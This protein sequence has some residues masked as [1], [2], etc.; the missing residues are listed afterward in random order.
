MSSAEP[1]P[2]EKRRSVA[3]MINPFDLFKKLKSHA[4]ACDLNED[5]FLT[6]VKNLDLDETSLA[7]H[8]SSARTGVRSPGGTR[9]DILVYKKYRLYGRLLQLMGKPLAETYFEENGTATALNLE[10]LNRIINRGLA[11][12]GMQLRSTT[13]N[14]LAALA[15]LSSALRN[16]RRDSVAVTGDDADTQSTVS[17]LS[18]TV[19][20]TPSSGSRSI[21][22]AAA[23]GKLVPESI[24]QAFGA[25]TLTSSRSAPSLPEP[26]RLPPLKPARSS[27]HLVRASPRTAASDGDSTTAKIQALEQENATLRAT[28]EANVDARRLY[29]L[30]C[31][32]AQLSAQVASQNDVIKRWATLSQ[33]MATGMDNLQRMCEE[34]VGKVEPSAKPAPDQGDKDKKSTAS[35]TAV[36]AT[37]A[38][39]IQETARRLTQRLHDKW[40]DHDPP[41]SR[42]GSFDKQPVPLFARRPGTARTDVPATVDWRKV[43][44][45]EGQLA[46]LHGTLTGLDAQLA[47]TASSLVVL[48]D[49]GVTR[50]VDAAE[51]ARGEVHRTAGMLASVSSLAGIASGNARAVAPRARANVDAEVAR[52]GDAAERLRRQLDPV[53]A[54]KEIAQGLT[55]STALRDRL[56]AWCAQTQSLVQRELAVLKSENE[57]TRR[58]VMFQRALSERQ[59]AHVDA[60]LRQLDNARARLLAVL[61]TCLEGPLTELSEALAAVKANYSND[62]ALACL[63]LADTVVVEMQGA[64]STQLTTPDNVVFAAVALPADTTASNDG[65]AGAS[66]SVSTA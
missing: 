46:S 66:A 39:L 47:M 22:V 44:A 40:L 16:K 28:L 43:T 61:Q 1:I 62:A 23:R 60:I 45:L 3:T 65:V 25:G 30:Q 29:F 52:L 13:R 33:E 20:L 7:R 19:S 6:I 53:V 55:L 26:T 36:A 59:S 42:T 31:Q 5:E 57:V 21:I 11:E 2:T 54:T 48:T 15:F 63:K 51:H 12:L 37:T 8:G 24:Q 49:R 58:E 50:L 9:A 4:H 64:I 14:D 56:A 35:A 34:L 27:T 10:T 32:N 41:Q 38:K 18:S 17:T